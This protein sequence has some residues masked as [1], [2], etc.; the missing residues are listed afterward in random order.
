MRILDHR[1]SRDLRRH[2]LALRMIRHEV[3]TSTIIT[4]T[5]LSETR[6]RGL[7]RSYIPE[8]VRSALR[9]RGP[10]PS[11]LLP[12]LR[13]SGLNLE[14]AGLAG[15]CFAI[16]VL[17]SKALADPSEVRSVSAG[18]R[19]CYAFELYQQLIPKPQ[20][21]LDQ[22]MILVTALA[23]GEEVALVHCTV[24]DGAMLIALLRAQRRVCAH[25]ALL[26]ASIPRDLS[27]AFRKRDETGAAQED[28]T[29]PREGFQRRLF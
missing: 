28:E 2:D 15:V 26:T 8:G 1:Y 5:G 27:G 21:T 16:G 13:S 6:I 3:R 14:A 17:P 20:I 24:C 11:S 25:C 7:Y 23:Q 4:W 19:L 12:L 9:H 29:D 18:E 22:L 10:S